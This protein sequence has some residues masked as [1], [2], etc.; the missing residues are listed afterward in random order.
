MISSATIV[1]GQANLPD[2]VHAQITDALAALGPGER[3]IFDRGASSA[4][5]FEW[6]YRSTGPTDR[7]ERIFAEVVDPSGLAFDEVAATDVHGA[8]H[9]APSVGH[10]GQPREVCGV[11]KITFHRRLPDVTRETYLQRFREHG[12]IAKVHHSNAGR[13]RQNEVTRYSGPPTRFADGVSEHWYRA[14]D[15]AR[16]RH[17]ARPESE[18][19]VSADVAGWLDRSTA[20]GGYAFV[21]QWS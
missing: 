11:R 15:E 17:F 18:R 7:I 14:V 1:A 19:I 6:L 21:W 13:Y 8:D 4:R 16:A 2:D 12:A 20:V 3:A 10:R 9:A 5:A